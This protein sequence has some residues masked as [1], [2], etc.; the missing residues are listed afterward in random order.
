MVVL[1]YQAVGEHLRI[2][3]LQALPHDAQQRHAAFVIRDD[4]LAPITT[5]GD[6]LDGTRELNT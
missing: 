5:R 6:V 3:A 4:A 2:E 1:A